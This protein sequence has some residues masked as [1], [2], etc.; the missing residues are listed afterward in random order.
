MAFYVRILNFIGYRFINLALKLDNVAQYPPDVE[1]IYKKDDPFDELRTTYPLVENSLIVDVGGFTGDWAM[2]MYA[3]Y[4]CYIDIYEPHPILASES[5]RNFRTNKKV[6]TFPIGMSD[7]DGVLELYGDTM[8]ASL[9]NNSI[10]KVNYVDIKKASD[11]FK[12][13]YNDKEIDLLKIN[14]EG[15]EYDLLPDLMKNWDIRKV[16]FILVQF[17]SHVPIRA[18]KREMIRNDLSKTHRMVWGY[19]FIFESWVRNDVAV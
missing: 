5:M 4:S 18:A 11:I 19:D 12:E 13:R 3:L 9:F 2:R 6:R 10:G 16:K 17:H 14:I 8:N 15:A 1:K 7:K